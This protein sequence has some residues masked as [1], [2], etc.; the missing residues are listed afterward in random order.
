MSV[1]T[2]A[3]GED[4]RPQRMDRFGNPIISRATTLKL[5]ALES[6]KDSPVKKKDKD[7]KKTKHKLS[8]IDKPPNDKDNE[9]TRLHHV[10][11]YKK[12]NSMNTYDPYYVEEGEGSSHCCTIF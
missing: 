3:L 11:S 7:D 2:P 5:V 9:L 10:Q 4:G 8:F 1:P 12:Y 6:G